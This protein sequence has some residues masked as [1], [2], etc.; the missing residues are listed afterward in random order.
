MWLVV[1]VSFWLLPANQSHVFSVLPRGK[2]RLIN[3]KEGSMVDL[4][5]FSPRVTR[6][7]RSLPC[8]HG[9]FE[10]LDSARDVT[11]MGNFKNTKSQ[12][13][14]QREKGCGASYFLSFPWPMAPRPPQKIP[15]SSWIRGSSRAASWPLVLFSDISSPQCWKS[16]EVDNLD[17]VTKTDNFGTT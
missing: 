10:S 7:L 4:L 2:F 17:Q 6:S 9:L 15:R 16:C 1:L 8:T 13:K 11:I 3:W 14:T 12:G 5:R